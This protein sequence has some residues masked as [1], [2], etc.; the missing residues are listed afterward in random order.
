MKNKTIAV[1]G[2]NHLGMVTT[3]CMASLGYQI[4]AI[5]LNKKIT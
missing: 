4:K 2:L 1:I 3:A 5:D